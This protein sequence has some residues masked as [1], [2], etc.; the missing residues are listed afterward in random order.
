MYFAEDFVKMELLNLYFI[1]SSCFRPRWMSVR[2]LTK[3]PSGRRQ[4]VRSSLTCRRLTTCYD[5]GTNSWQT[6]NRSCRIYTNSPMR[7]SRSV[8]ELGGDV[9]SSVLCLHCVRVRYEPTWGACGHQQ[10]HWL[11]N[12]MFCCHVSWSPEAV[13]LGVYC[14][15]LEFEYLSNFRMIGQP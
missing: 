9:D 3:W 7:L 5:C 6:S 1:T 11:S 8:A 13:R 10:L 2:P 12:K 4:L 14:I 15:A